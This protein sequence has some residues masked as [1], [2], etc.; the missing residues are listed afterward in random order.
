MMVYLILLVVIIILSFILRPDE[1]GGGKATFIL[2]SF[3]LMGALSSLRDFSVG[4]DTKQYLLLYHNA[5]YLSLNSYVLS[6]YEPGFV[7]LCKILNLISHDPRLL[8]A[9]CSAAVFGSM[10][11]FVYRKSANCTFST[12]FVILIQL[13]PLYMSAMRQA[14]AFSIILVAYCFFEKRKIVLFVASVVLAAQFHVSALFILV[15]LPLIKMGSF[16]SKTALWVFA[17]AVGAAVLSPI[18]FDIVGRVINEKYLLYGSVSETNLASVLTL[19]L[20]VLLATIQGFFSNSSYGPVK[21]RQD[22]LMQLVSILSLPLAALALRTSFF[23]RLIYYTCFF[24]GVA[25]PLLFKR[26]SSAERNIMFTLLTGLFVAYFL[27]IG[28]FRPDWFGAIPYTSA[29]LG[30]G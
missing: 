17:I 23:L 26:V 7:L 10:G 27:V 8:L 11:L 19:A 12:L 5:G 9:V 16:S 24:Y 28:V 30:I 20:F 6:R 13:Y 22:T 25:I 21:G 14:V 2:I 4:N 18:L 29:I 15:L 3:G 1:D